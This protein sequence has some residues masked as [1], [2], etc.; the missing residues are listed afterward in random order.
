MGRTDGWLAFSSLGMILL[1]VAGV[2]W[3]DACTIEEAAS[4]P[5][6][7][8]AP[9]DVIE[10]DLATT[11][12]AEEDVVEPPAPAILAATPPMGWSSWNLFACE[13]DEDLIKGIADAMVE[14]GMA[15]AGYEYVNLDDC[16]QVERDADGAIVADPVRFPGG[17]PALADYVHGRGLKLGIYTCAG[18]LT[19]EDRPG[20]LGYEAQDMQTYADW[21]V[22][23]VKVD[24]CYAEH[25]DAASQ[26]ALFRD[27]ILAS[28]REILL[29]IC[30]WGFQDPWVWGPGIGQMWRT[31]GDIKDGFLPLMYNLMAVEPLAAFAG[32]GRWNDPDMLEVGNGGMS[33]ELYRAHMGLWAM[34]AAPL[35]AGNDLR[36]MS[37]ETLSL[38]TNPEIIAVDQDPA[39][40]QAVL[41]RV[42]DDVRIYAR[43]LEA[44]AERAVLFFNTSQ[45][46][47]RTASI[48]WDELGLFQ[49]TASVRDL[50]AGEDL[51]AFVDVFEAEVP[52]T[53]AVM[54]TIR[55]T[56]PLPGA[57]T[58]YLSDLSFKHAASHGAPIERLGPEGGLGVPGGS[59]VVVHLGGRCEV[60]E[61][62]VGLMPDAGADGSVTF[63]VWGDGDRLW[64]SDVVTSATDPVPIQVWAQG[65]QNLKL[66][67]T[68]AGDSTA[69]DRAAWAQARLTCE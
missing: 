3:M 4:K 15:E 65:R 55:G 6:D 43:A 42:S 58:R 33:D 19:C 62:T 23:F 30:N 36:D 28:G 18:E 20:S 63:E 38:L 9:E 32:P 59:L 39:G 10:G 48:T 47:A 56:E 16:W 8:A 14:S 66:V 31:S 46:E 7:V 61:A 22:D 24:W 5:P 27:G 25:L 60:F 51:G 50:F 2:L 17:I 54:V 53:G 11:D 64:A 13:I 68:P 34:L 26:Y 57:G 52:P 45:T 44:D 41:L 21:G 49:G 12:A 29:S 40:L 37:A 67:T 35:I 1:L 69:G